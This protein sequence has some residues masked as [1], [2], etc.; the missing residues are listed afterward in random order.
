MNKIRQFIADIYHCSD[1]WGVKQSEQDMYENLL[2][3]N[4]E[5][6]DGYVPP[7]E[8]YKECTIAWNKLCDLYPS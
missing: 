1:S 8:S 2:A 7:V 5:I 4:K 3:W 6:T